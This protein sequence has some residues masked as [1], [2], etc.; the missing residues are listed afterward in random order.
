MERAKRVLELGTGLMEDQGQYS[1]QAAFSL[2]QRVARFR[3][4]ASARSAVRD[5]LEELKVR[6]LFLWRFRGESRGLRRLGSVLAAQKD[7]D[8][9]L[10]PPLVLESLLLRLAEKS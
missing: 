7:L 6:S 4:F 9:N 3:N 5:F 2:S 8:A 1:H 10:S